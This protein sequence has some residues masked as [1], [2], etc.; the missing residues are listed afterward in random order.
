MPSDEDWRLASQIHG[1]F[2][3]KPE[4]GWIA[5]AFTLAHVSACLRTLQPETVLELGAGIGT[6]TNLLLTHPAAPKQLVTT[7][8]NEVCLNALST[9]L[10][11]VDRSG[12][13]LVNSV[14]ELLDLDID[15]SLAIC[16]GGFKE[17]EQF[18]GVHAGTV[19]VFDGVRGT[20]RRALSDYLSQRSLKCDI[21]N[22]QQRRYK[23]SLTQHNTGFGFSLPIPRVQR[24]RGYWIG[25]VQADLA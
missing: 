24:R 4:S 25:T 8:P 18:K 7:E 12:M 15:Y 9:N 16:D 11:D 6:V 1:E 13:I 2:S 14:E 10:A 21:R 23:I 22:C 17:P 3:L 19:C 20:H 5:S